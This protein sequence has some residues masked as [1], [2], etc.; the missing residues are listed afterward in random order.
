M[1]KLILLFASISAL[2]ANGLGAFG[3]HAL[4]AKLPHNLMITY[5]TGVQYQFYHSL[6]LLLI[7]ILMFHV[8]N[9]WIALSGAS[10]ATGI[11]LFSGSLYVLSITGI[12]AFGI[13]TPFGGLAFMAGWLLLL[14]SLIKEKSI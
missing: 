4:K 14:V 5:Q 9:I 12:K 6:G 1:Q 10:I 8:K 7:G 2:F 3:A 13:I 11:L